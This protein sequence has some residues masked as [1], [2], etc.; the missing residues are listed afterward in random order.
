MLGRRRFVVGAGAGAL[1][2]AGCG[3]SHESD[4]D[5]GAIVTPGEDL[6]GEHG[7]VRRVMVVWNELDGRL[8]RG[9]PV[10]AAPL[11][12]SVD[13]VQWFIERNHERTEENEVFPRL[14]HA[15][16][17]EA[18]VRTLLAQHEVGRA[19]TRELAS[20][21]ASEITEASRPRLITLLADHSRMY[22]AHASR[23]D[24]IVF[25]ALRE[26]VGEGWAELGEHFE[27][28]EHHTLGEG[29][30][31]RAVAQVAAVERAYGIEDLASFTPA[32]IRT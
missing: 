24:T 4:D 29:G 10:D 26:L 23:E 6:M 32:T 13:L 16:R 31:E 5:N 22:A 27:E 28:N 8:R 17:E 3:Q 18:L 1:G 9:E 15:G 2:L 14:M 21:A 25:P 7:I 12:S 19:M 11:A 20:L 30:F